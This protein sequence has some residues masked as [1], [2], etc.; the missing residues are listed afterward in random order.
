MKVNKLIV[1]LMVFTVLNSCKKDISVDDVLYDFSL[2]KAEVIADGNTSIT[3]TVK[4]NNKAS[5]DRRTVIFS[6]SNGSFGE[7]V[8][9][10]VKAEFTEGVLTAKASFK[11]STT[12][13][14]ITV[15]VQPEFDARNQEFK[16][17][18]KVLSTASSARS[19]KI[20][21][22]SFGLASNFVTEVGLTAFIK[23]ADGGFASAGQKVIFEDFL[24]SGMP[25]NG[26]FRNI[27]AV[28]TD[29]SKVGAIYSAPLLPI[30]T[31]IN[32][33]CTLLD[34]SG[35]KMNISDA[36]TLTINL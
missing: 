23:N 30:G 32:I 33:R 12:P 31:N 25:A 8:K 36:V 10:T 21:P 19:V 35:N 7:G 18:R 9:K 4:L 15:S 3:L 1:G 34:N 11:V 26:R 24:T 6:T 2:D 29:S 27:K 17:S 22:S 28:T 14:E 20:E 16:L 13:G 5:A